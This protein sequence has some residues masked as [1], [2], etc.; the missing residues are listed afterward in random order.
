MPYFDSQISFS[1]QERYRYQVSIF[2]K[3]CPVCTAHHSLNAVRCRCGYCF[4]PNKL[5]GVTQELEVI[6]QEEKLFRDYLAARADQAEQAWRAAKAA[7]AIDPTRAAQVKSAEQAMLTA[8]V[9][10]EAQNEKARAVSTRI[11]VIRSDRRARKQTAASSASTSTPASAPKP[12][13]AFRASQANKAAQIAVASS[14][15]GPNECPNCMAKI[16]PHARRCRCGFELPT[17]TSN[18]PALPMTPAERAAFLAA[19]APSGASRKNK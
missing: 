6:A 17:S 3:D 13:P 9:E 10:L 7:A 14:V 15:P 18:I 11:K 16:P 8:R 19:L 1:S 12:T 2:T 4:E 5:D